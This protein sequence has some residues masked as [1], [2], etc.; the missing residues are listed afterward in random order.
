MLDNRLKGYMKR[1]EGAALVVNQTQQ[2]FAK[3]H[4][5]VSVHSEFLNSSFIL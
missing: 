2:K 4:Q 5:R 3:S 1:K